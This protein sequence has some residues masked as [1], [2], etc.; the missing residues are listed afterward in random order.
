MAISFD[1]IENAFL[2]VCYGP[3]HS[4]YAY[5]NKET[6]EIY[7]TSDMGDSDI[8]PDDIE[9][10]KYITLPD[11]YELNLGKTLVFEFT[12]QFLPEES[13]KV[14]SIFGHKGAYSRFKD[15]LERKGKIDE[16]YKYEDERQKKALK[17]WCHDNGIKVTG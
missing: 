14:Y 5:L 17:E 9:D 3:P 8:L 10:E 15:L 6:G 2:F 1:D 12:S 4:H 13:E 7:Y 16:W 11:K